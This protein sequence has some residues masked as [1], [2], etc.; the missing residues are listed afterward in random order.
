MYNVWRVPG[1]TL[2]INTSENTM[3]TFQIKN[4]H[5][6]IRSC[7]L[8]RWHTAKLMLIVKTY[9]W[10]AVALSSSWGDTTRFPFVT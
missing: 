10:P 3:I 7:D 8:M 9:I 1:V 4:M 2:G 5:N 6:A